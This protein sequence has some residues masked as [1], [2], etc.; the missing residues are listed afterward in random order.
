MTK[1]LLHI[2]IGC[3]IVSCTA[4]LIFAIQGCWVGVINSPIV[5]LNLWIMYFLIGRHA[6]LEFRYDLMLRLAKE[7]MTDNGKLEQ[8]L[9]DLYTISKF[10]E[11]QKESNETQD[12]VQTSQENK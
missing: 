11:E 8:E 2:C 9:K 4:S 10:M 1:H 3:S 6:E 5:T 12:N 7:V